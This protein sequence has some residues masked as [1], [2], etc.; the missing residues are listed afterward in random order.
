MKFGIIQCTKCGKAHGIALRF[1]TTT[2]PYCYKKLK[3]NQKNIKF[4]SNSE[5]DLSGIIGDINNKVMTA[6]AGAQPDE[7]LRFVNAASGQA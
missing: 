1:S 5:A 3:I 7:P 6:A 4:Q 2:C